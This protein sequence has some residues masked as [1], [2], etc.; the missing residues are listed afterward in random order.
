LHWRSPVARERIMDI[1]DILLL[2]D[3][4]SAAANHYAASLAAKLDAHLTVAT[5]VIDP[6]TVIAFS[7]ES[8]A[9][10]AAALDEAKKEAEAIAKDVMAAAEREQVAAQTQFVSFGVGTIGET[11]GRL[12]HRFDLTIIEQPN[13]AVPTERRSLINA[14]LFDS[15]RPLLVTPYV[16]RGTRAETILVAWDNSVHA[17]RA[18]ADAL[19]WLRKA[20]KVEVASIEDVNKDDVAASHPGLREHLAR[21]GI[22]A[23]CRMLSSAGDVGNTLLSYSFDMGADLLVMGA[24]GHSRL[25]ELILG[26]ATREILASMTLPALMS[27]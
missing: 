1:K 19:P 8:S 27:H 7:D 16:Q 4:A 6:A 21:H 15:G 18:L 25:R 12:I 2:A 13:P 26:G 20:K 14:A 3:S 23:E 17:A 24:Y 9:L 5:P 22:A 11:L 10:V